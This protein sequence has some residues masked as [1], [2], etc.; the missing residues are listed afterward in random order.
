MII[1]AESSTNIEIMATVR[2]PVNNE[3]T[4][5]VTFD[6]LQAVPEDVEE[7][8]QECHHQHSIK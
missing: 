3:Q 5:S 2:W 7:A 1:E 8:D 4:L 6:K